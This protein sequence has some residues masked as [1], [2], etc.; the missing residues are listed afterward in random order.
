M[1]C[2]PTTSSSPIWAARPKAP[3]RS[4]A[5]S[6]CFTTCSLGGRFDL[7]ETLELLAGI[8]NLL[9]KDFNDFRAYPLRNNLDVAAF[10][11][12][13][14]NIEEPHRLWSSLRAEF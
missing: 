9:G 6:R 11:I 8:D 14:N 1:A 12:V 2:T 3:P 10:S 13:Y 7:S 5:T 4:W